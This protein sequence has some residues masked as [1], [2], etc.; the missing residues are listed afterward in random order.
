VPRRSNKRDLASNKASAKLMPERNGTWSL[1]Y[2]T[3]KDRATQKEKEVTLVFTGPL[4]LPI[5]KKRR[6][7]RG[8]VS[9]RDCNTPL[10]VVWKDREASAVKWAKNQGCTFTFQRDERGNQGKGSRTFSSQPCIRGVN[11]KTEKP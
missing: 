6:Q 4:L 9:P 3:A 10:T 8:D 7:G 1:H 5:E 11:V 2:S